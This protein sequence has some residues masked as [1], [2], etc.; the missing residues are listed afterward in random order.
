MEKYTEVGGYAILYEN[1]GSV[2]CPQCADIEI[3]QGT[4]KSDFRSFIHWE[5]D[6]IDCDGCNQPQESEYGPIED[7]KEGEKN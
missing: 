3:S 1:K 6:S 5:G 4:L 2:Y 7:N